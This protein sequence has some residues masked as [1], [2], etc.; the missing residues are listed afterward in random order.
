MAKVREVGWEPF[1]WQIERARDSDFG[2]FLKAVMA[3]NAKLEQQ[4]TS[5]LRVDSLM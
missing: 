3:Q 2:H 5:R 4:A 1:F